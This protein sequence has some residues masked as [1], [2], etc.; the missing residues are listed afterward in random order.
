MELDHDLTC[1]ELVEFLSE[2]I[3]GTLSAVEVAVFE[4]HLSQCRD[5]RVYIESYRMTMRLTRETSRSGP[6]G[7][8]I[9]QSLVEAIKSAQRALE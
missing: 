1:R 6:D 7:G 5:C 9:P 3:D 2:Y 8:G 4:E